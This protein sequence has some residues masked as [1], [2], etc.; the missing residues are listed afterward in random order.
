MI[1]KPVYIEKI[2][3]EEVIVETNVD[4]IVM[5]ETITEEA[6]EVDD[7]QLTSE[8]HTRKSELE[9]QTRENQ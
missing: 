5:D 9:S 4:E 3:E 8:I 1:E 2:V 6:R 7:H